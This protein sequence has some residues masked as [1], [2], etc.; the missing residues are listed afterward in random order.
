MLE[1]KLGWVK[2]EKQL[3]C[4]CVKMVVKGREEMRGLRGVVHMMKSKKP[5]TEPWGT[6][7]QEAYKD[8][9]VLSHLTGKEQD[10][11]TLSHHMEKIQGRRPFWSSE[12][13]HF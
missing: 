5:R 9:N 13:L 3:S 8:E 4:I 1:L 12:N 6:P 10:S 11:I 7:Q 2:G